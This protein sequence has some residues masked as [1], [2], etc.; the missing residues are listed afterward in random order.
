MLQ[1]ATA[2]TKRKFEKAL[3]NQKND[4]SDELLKRK[5]IIYTH[6]DEIIG[7]AEN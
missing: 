5:K 1:L 6:D 4:I 3:G 7:G 2:D